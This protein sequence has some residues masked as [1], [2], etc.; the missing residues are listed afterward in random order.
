LNDESELK[1][2]LAEVQALIEAKLKSGPVS[3]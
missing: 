2:W 1:L 3:L